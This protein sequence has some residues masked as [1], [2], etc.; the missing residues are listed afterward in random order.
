MDDLDHSIHIAE[1][2]WS[3]FYDD[4]EKCNLLQVS[5]AYPDDFSLSDS[6]DSGNFNTGQQETKRSAASNTGEKS[7]TVSTQLLEQFVQSAA[8]CMKQ[9]EISVSCPER[10]A[11]STECAHKEITQEILVETSASSPNTQEMD[12]L[13]NYNSGGREML[14]KDGAAQMKIDLKSTK[15]PDLLSCKQAAPSVSQPDPTG[16]AEKERWFVTVNDNQAR[17]PGR[18]TSVKKKLKQKKPAEGENV[19]N[20]DIKQEHEES[21]DINS[22]KNKESGDLTEKLIVSQAVAVMNSDKCDPGS[23][24]DTS[25]DSF[26]PS[27]T[28]L[29]CLLCSEL[30]DGAEFSSTGS[31]DSESYLSAAE[32]VEEAQL[33]LQDRLTKHPP[34]QCA[35]SPTC[36]SRDFSFALSCDATAANFEGYNTPEPIF[37]PL[38]AKMLH[39]NFTSGNEKC[40]DTHPPPLPPGSSHKDQLSRLPAPDLTLTLCSAADSPETFAKAAGQGQ[41]YA[42]SAFWDEVE[43]LTINDILQVRMGRSSRLIEETVMPNACG[44]P[45][46]PSHLVDTIDNTL[47]DTSDTADSDYFTQPDE[48]KP[49]QSVREFSTSDFEEE[50]WQLVHASRK[51]SPDLQN[52]NQQSDSSFLLD[53]DSSTDSEGWETPIV[54]DKSFDC[55]DL[56]RL[57]SCMRKMTKSRS[58]CNVQSLNTEDL[59]SLPVLSV[60]KTDLPLHRHQPLE[61]VLSHPDFQDYRISFPEIFEYFFTECDNNTQSQFLTVHDAK[62]I[63]VSPVFHSPLYTFREYPSSFPLQCRTEKPIPIFSCSRPTVRDLTFPNANVFLSAD[64]E[65]V[66]KVSP[67]RLVSH[68]F[69]QASP[70]RSSGAEGVGRSHCW[71]CFL[72]LRK[73]RFP[74]KG[75]ICCS[76][77]GT[78]IFPVET[79]EI[80]TGRQ[81]QALTLLS[82]G[83]VCLDFRELEEQQTI[84]ETTWIT[85]R[86]GIFSRV[87]QSDMCLVCIAFASWV[88]SSSNPDPADAWKTA[89]LANVSA[90]SAI[91]Y[92]RQ[93]MKSKNPP[94][95]DL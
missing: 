33:P 6:E 16:T 42:I 52:K 27:P 36:D 5:L 31:W 68:L 17:R 39:E 87:K 72:S 54:L 28:V 78:W 48:S 73:I 66:D 64:H 62:E 8:M 37:T 88:L 13:S 43:K 45:T 15:K 65:E 1:Y 81:N 18:S 60:D 14:S 86:E 21:K 89:L 80:R 50:T 29:E 38:S 49:D 75:S 2:D 3:T 22:N 47:M 91:Q 24:T 94:I 92:L 63:V 61:A 95:D 26:S 55:E 25:Y 23:S 59:P 79:K 70:H 19:E 83:R 20:A 84:L 76:E 67:M 44:H 71:K 56:Q 46:N 7:C 41:V 77:S 9:V 40:S 53:E 69:I 82:D 34:L 4:S 85:K 58:M 90:L 32:S 11:I 12:P 10:N 35:L 30:Q 93:Y 57:I 51:S 74:D